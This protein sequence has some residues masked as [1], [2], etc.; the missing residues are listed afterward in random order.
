M[1]ADLFYTHTRSLSECERETGRAKDAYQHAPIV[2][3]RIICVLYGV[4][5]VRLD[6]CSHHFLPHVLIPAMGMLYI[7]RYVLEAL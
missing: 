4:F 3:I 5:Y 6:L 1:V 2:V 7:C